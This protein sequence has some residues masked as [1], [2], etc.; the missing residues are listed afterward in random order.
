HWQE[1]HDPGEGDEYDEPDDVRQHERYHPAKDRHEAQIA[2]DRVDDEYV[3]S[4]RRR[5]Q[6]QFDRHHDDDTEPDR[7]EAKLHDDRI[8]DWHQQDDHRHRIEDAAHHQK[9]SEDDGQR[10]IWSEVQPYKERG[11]L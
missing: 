9:Q 1:K 3:H 4:H 8:D 10:S 2:R 11:D 7:V 6:P 5:D